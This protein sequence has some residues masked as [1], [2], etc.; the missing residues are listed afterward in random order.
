MQELEMRDLSKA[1]RPLGSLASGPI[2]PGS[3]FAAEQEE[4]SLAVEY[5]RM[6][7]RRRWLVL[8]ATVCGALIG[9]GVTLPREPLFR[10]HT[11]LDVQGV[12]GNFMNMQTLD[13]RATP[14]E[15]TAESFLQT[16]IKLL[17]SESIMTRAINK[18]RADMPAAFESRQDMLSLLRERLGFSATAPDSAEDMIRDV[19]KSVKVKPMGMT[20][21]V[22]ITCESPS[23]ALAA[24]FCNTLASEFINNDLEVRMETAQKTGTYLSQQLQDVKKNLES[25]ERLLQSYAQQTTLLSSGDKEGVA[26]EKL[27]QL[28]SE[29]SQAQADRIVK[30]SQYE[31][32][33]SA[34]ADSL[35]PVLD[36]G[37]LREYQTKLADLKQQ[38]ADISTSFTSDYP[39]VQRVDAQIKELESTIAKERQNTVSRIK[40][41]YEAAKHREVMLASAYGSQAKM[42][43]ALA[44]KEAQYN[45]LQHEVESDRQL[46]ENLLQRVKEAGFLSAMRASPVRVVDAALEPRLPVS[47]QPLISTAVGLILGGLAGV[48][49]AFFSD[50]TDRRL[51]MPGEAPLQLRIRELGVIPAASVDRLPK[52]PVKA[53]TTAGKSESGLKL[54]GP[55]AAVSST[56]LELVTWFNKGSLMA[57]SY[58]G[59]MSSLLFSGIKPGEKMTLVVTSPSVSEG[60]T[61]LLSNLGIALAQT[62]RSVVLIDGDLRRPR[63]HKIFH[64]DNSMGLGNVLM[65]DVDPITCP[66]DRIV[67]ATT[68]PGLYVV[69]AGTPVDDAASTL[70]SPHLA[71]LIER[72]NREFSALLIDS[73]PMLHLTDARVLARYADGVVL[74]VRAG[75]TTMDSAANAQQIFDADGTPIVGTVLN[76]F[77]PT[78][79][80][81]MH[82]YKSYRQYQEQKSA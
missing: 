27:R 10:A 70:F 80:L 6:L 22:A 61:T 66:L 77:D 29:L 9:F 37:P 44:P 76:D 15:Q 74:V 31:L 57:E 55:A 56:N 72:L 69:P 64:V 3:Q 81:N 50:R 59:V 32:T 43:S 48:L 24:K 13:P 8:G 36:S 25:K 18:V 33:T 34:S 30:Q 38:Y 21:L 47:P 49:I 51:Q 26:Q 42:V 54:L 58:R 53:L 68:V 71:T 52:V 78:H 67:R 82:Y 46:Y 16:E 20:R 63:L 1:V 35:P 41:D 39:K 62:K 73:P 12:N 23:A 79:E 14:G 40:N 60:K 45:M 11:S 17:Q 19:A 5:F 7:V 75:A 28:Q 2:I 65:G 4:P